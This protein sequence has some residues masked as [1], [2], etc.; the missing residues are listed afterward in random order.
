MRCQL[1]TPTT[2]TQLRLGN[3]N[4]VHGVSQSS[5]LGGVRYCKRCRGDA[6]KT[7]ATVIDR[8][9]TDSQ[10]ESQPAAS[11]SASATLNI[12]TP[13]VNGDTRR[14]GNS[15]VA[16]KPR[17]LVVEP[18]DFTLEPGELSF[19]D[20]DSKCSPKDVFRCIGCTDARC[21]VCIPVTNC[22]KQPSSSNQPQLCAL[23]C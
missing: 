3:R 21:Q 2:L 11:S 5:A 9:S 15:A 1:G 18:S 23:I 22:G 17:S 16:E 14:N 6:C 19:V 10:S 13:S 7:Q 20:R 4:L 12:E 8:S